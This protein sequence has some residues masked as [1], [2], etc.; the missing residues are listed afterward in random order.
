MYRLDCKTYKPMIDDH[1]IATVE[2]DIDAE[3]WD[4]DYRVVDIMLPGF[5][6][7]HIQIPIDQNLPISVQ[8][9]P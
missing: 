8:L 3:N 2:V 7:L 6:Q 1:I 5:Q 4:T 9:V